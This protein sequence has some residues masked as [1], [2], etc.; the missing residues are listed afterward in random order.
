MLKPN[1]QKLIK[2]KAPFINENIRFSNCQNITWK[3]I[4]YNVDKTEIHVQH[5]YIR[6]MPT[7]VQTP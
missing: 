3:H 4:Q 2:V 1:E 7:M 5:S 6:H